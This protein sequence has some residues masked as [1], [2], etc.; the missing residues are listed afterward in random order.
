MEGLDAFAK[1]AL[2]FANPLVLVDVAL[3]L[4]LGIDRMLSK[5]QCCCTEAWN[6]LARTVSTSQDQCQAWRG[7]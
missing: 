7:S 1:I 2:H 4:F 3:L 6:R 5:A